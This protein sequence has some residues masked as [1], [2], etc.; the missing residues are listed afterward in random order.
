MNNIFRITLQMYARN[1]INAFFDKLFSYF[2]AKFNKNF[3]VV[4][5]KL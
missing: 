5:D 2:P 3:A 1:M 4:Y